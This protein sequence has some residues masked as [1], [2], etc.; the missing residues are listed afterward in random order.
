MPDWFAHLRRRAANARTPT[1]GPGQRTYAIGDVHG[2]LAQ[3]QALL[4]LIAADNAQRASAHVTL[5]YVGDYIDRGANSRGVL[6]EVRKPV[7]GIDTVVHIKGNHEAMLQMFLRD[8]VLAHGWLDNGGLE[9][10]TS[11]GV[12][13]GMAK[14]G[15]DLETTRNALSAAIGSDLLDW[16]ADRPLTHQIGDYFFCHAGVRPGIALAGQSEQDLLWIR[17]PF[18]R[19]RADFGAIVVHGHTPGHEPEVRRNRI[20]L[21]TGCFASGRLTAAVFDGDAA[22]TMLATAG[23]VSA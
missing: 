9:T 17:E 8:P 2:C 22:V 18:L 10:L 13:G 20:N 11:F 19:S 21:D 1:V 12:D 7:A 16:L 5:V 4:K 14:R 6:D 23:R 3:L 15:L